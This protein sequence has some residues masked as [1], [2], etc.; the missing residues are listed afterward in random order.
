MTL[1]T[2]APPPPD[3]T[4]TR[5][6]IRAL[7]ALDW[8]DTRRLPEPA[9]GSTW[10]LVRMDPILP[11]RVGQLA[12]VELPAGLSLAARCDRVELNA[13]A[14]THFLSPVEAAIAERAVAWS[15]A[16]AALADRS[17]SPCP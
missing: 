9:E 15:M 14:D 16:L 7:P 10:H 5:E 4:I 1:M 2:T 6:D 8:C 3:V 12:W 11:R 17:F 13:Q